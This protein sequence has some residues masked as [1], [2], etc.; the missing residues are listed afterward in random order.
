MPGPSTNAPAAA[1]RRALCAARRPASRLN[2]PSVPDHR[3]DGSWRF[4]GEGSSGFWR[5]KPRSS[6]RAT[7]RSTIRG[8]L[9]CASLNVPTEPPTTTFGC[10][11][12]AHRTT[13]RAIFSGLARNPLGPGVPP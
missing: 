10:G 3:G 4:P 5:K 2:P 8:A 6:V 7:T 13:T 12:S 11:L 1:A 9:A